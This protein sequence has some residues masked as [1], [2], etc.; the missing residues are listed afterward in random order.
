M[1]IS[2][3]LYVHIFIYRRTWC[4][5]E[6]LQFAWLW[7]AGDC[8]VTLHANASV[9]IWFIRYNKTYFAP[10]FEDKIWNMYAFDKHHYT[11]YVISQWPKKAYSNQ[12]TQLRSHM[13]FFPIYSSKAFAAL[14]A[15]LWSGS[16]QALMRESGQ[17]HQKLWYLNASDWIRSV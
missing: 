15:A 8:S 6:C 17:L 16:K 4:G 13:L 5:Y 7:M 11:F 3:I 12:N 9:L 14:T 1:F 2:V 10:R